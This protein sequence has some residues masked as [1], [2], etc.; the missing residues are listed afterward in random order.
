VIEYPDVKANKKLT[1]KGWEDALFSAGTWKAT[2]TGEKVHGSL[3]DYYREQSHGKFRIEG[4]AFA[5]VLVSKKRGEYVEGSGTSNKTVLPTEA[6][7]KL[8]EREGEDRL[9]GF[10]GVCFIYA[11]AR[12][13]S[14]AGGLYY[15]HQGTLT[16]QG[17]RLDYMLCAEG[18]TTMEPTAQFALVFSK[19]IGLPSLA[20]R[21]ENAGSEGLGRW[22]LTSDGARGWKPA[23][24]SAWCK[25]QLGWIDPVV[26]DPTVP[27]KLILGPAQRSAK[28]CYKILV[29]L[30]GSE[31]F[32]LENR[33][34]TGFDGELPGQG[35]LIWRVS[36][37]RPILEESHGVTGP[38]G[39]LVHLPMVP[40]PSKA[41]NA[42]T[43]ITTPSSRAAGGGGL[44][45]YVTNIRR[46]SD[47]RV[48]LHV[49]YP[50]Q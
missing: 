35:L 50:Y 31:Y 29:R 20:A 42:F 4:R 37:G 47:G 2:P 11:G 36:G 26:I 12:V 16:H 30:D 28:E 3:N 45:V 33:T 24:L 19:L 41:N 13:G 23:H 39:P 15:P 22:C 38:K 43:P 40:Y 44:P 18:G 25:E 8:L 7:A 27:Q 5:P 32:L 17:R 48:T 21:T 14:N 6:I 1:P 9:A 49:G 34:A 46:L 10:D